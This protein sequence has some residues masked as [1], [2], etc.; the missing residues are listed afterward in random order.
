MKFVDVPSTVSLHS[1]LENTAC[2][3]NPRKQN[4]KKTNARRR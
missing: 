3:P 4:N 2:K 1:L